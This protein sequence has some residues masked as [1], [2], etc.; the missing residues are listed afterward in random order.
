MNSD[1]WESGK[2]VGNYILTRL[3][4]SGTFGS[5]YLAHHQYLDRKVAIKFL[6]NGGLS[7]EEKEAF[8][9]EA[10]LLNLLK[11][12][13]VLPIIDVGI[14][15]NAPYMMLEYALGG[16]L[17]E[18]LRIRRPPMWEALL[19][20]SQIG[21][22]LHYAHQRNIV[23]RDLKPANVLF[24]EKGE[25]LLADFGI[26]ILLESGTQ[27]TNTAGTYPYMAPEQFEGLTSVKSDQYALA[28]L[29]YELLTGHTPITAPRNADYFTWK[30]KVLEDS[31]IIPSQ[32]NPDISG[33]IDSAILK[34]LEK[35]RKNRY[36]DISSFI[37][38]LISQTSLV[39]VSKFPTTL[40]SEPTAEPLL[41]EKFP[42]KT[43]EQWLAEANEYFQK[44]HFE[45]SL[46][47]YEQAIQLA[48]DRDILY[49]LKGMVLHA[50]KHFQDALKAY[51][52]AIRL[53]PH[54]AIFHINKGD[55]LRELKFYKEA[56]EV[57]E[58]GFHLSAN[59]ILSARAYSGTANAL[60]LLGQDEEALE[61][62]Q[63]A[64]LLNPQ[65]ASLYRSQGDLLRRLRRYEDALK[66]YESA[67]VLAPNDITIQNRKNITLKLLARPC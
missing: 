62:F 63:Q 6:H 20:L 8:F 33:H 53:S 54:K 7:K 57:Y 38:A 3:L 29:A 24:N 59:N 49:N 15:N 61:A 14:Q 45:E 21:Q 25:A 42:K 12:R 35:D 66:S 11:H 58:Q 4:G 10:N 30:S 60:L 13:H 1:N 32:I 28:C 52:E 17:S 56:I 41:I 48:P 51:H 44:N 9:H 16:S 67:L 31:P 46:K 55:T 65:N 22:A 64:I 39:D 50:L 2:Q 37:T 40:A 43:I 34:A 27:S 5:V 36:T 26:A 18:M 19:I 23:H 47:A